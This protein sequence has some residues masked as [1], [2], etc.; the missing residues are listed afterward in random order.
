MKRCYISRIGHWILSFML[1]AVF[2]IPTFAADELPAPG[3]FRV[4]LPM[5][6]YLIELQS[7]NR[8]NIAFVHEDDF[9]LSLRTVPDTDYLRLVL[10]KDTKNDPYFASA[11]IGERETLALEK[12][13]R[14]DFVIAKD[15]QNSTIT[16]TLLPSN[17]V[18]ASITIPWVFEGSATLAA[19]AE[20]ANAPLT[21]LD[22]TSP[23]GVVQTTIPNGQTP[24]TPRQSPSIGLYIGV[25]ALLLLL[26]TAVVLSQVFRK[27]I[28]TLADKSAAAM[29]ELGKKID[30][31]SAMAKR[32]APKKTPAPLGEPP[33]PAP[34]TIQ[35][36]LA[37]IAREIASAPEDVTLSGL[38]RAELSDIGAL[39]SFTLQMDTGGI[40]NNLS[41]DA[42]Q[43]QS[44]IE[45][46]NAYFSGKQKAIPAEY[47]M[48]TV[49]LSNRDVLLSTPMDTSPPPSFIHKKLGQMFSISQQSGNLYLHIDYFAYPTFLVQ[50]ALES[51]CLA[52][53]FDLVDTHGG[54]PALADVF[55]HKIL[56]IIPAQT[57][58]EGDSF[59]LTRRGRIVVD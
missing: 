8:A 22:V 5:D 30:L 56:E 34:S 20:E 18:C 24:K 43:S 41:S 37:E 3:S 55:Q 44:E 39:S 25:V 4:D 49:G 57:K 16:A 14:I 36:P 9:F 21:P 47:D 31:R 32:I 45:I 15:G 19:F 27:P 40:P 51:V 35:M 46:M 13:L 6:L 26:L 7:K 54:R 38:V 52:R 1:L 58:R 11:L 53:I 50:R 10:A 48:L 42:L 59:V 2:A 12:T 17:K 33:I 23:N 28:Q 29:R